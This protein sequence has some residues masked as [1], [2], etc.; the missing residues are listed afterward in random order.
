MSATE[1]KIKLINT[2]ISKVES[3]SKIE[4][5]STT[6]NYEIFNNTIE[7]YL[8]LIKLIQ[9]NQGFL[10]EKGKKI[11]SNFWAL[12]TLRP[13]QHFKDEYFKIL[14]ES[15]KN[16]QSNHL[17][18]IL[19]HLKLY[20]R[21]AYP[22]SHTTKLLHCINQ[23]IPIIDSKILNFFHIN[24]DVNKNE[25]LKNYLITHEAFQDAYKI[26]EKQESLNSL[27]GNMEDINP[28]FKK[29]TFSKK[30]DSLI[31]DIL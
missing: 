20:A 18:E 7:R 1:K 3:I 24:L 19:I 13:S 16:N 8:N 21:N 29:L 11:Y 14:E 5:S 28:K 25:R 31:T 4:I 15:I 2:I 23:S 22:F 17:E 12:G 9:H 27:F 10:D 6:I 26:I 30:L